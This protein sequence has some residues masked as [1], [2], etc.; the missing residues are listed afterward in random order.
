MK[1]DAHT[2]REYKERKYQKYRVEIPIKIIKELGWKKGQDLTPK[3]TKK[4]GL[5]I[6]KTK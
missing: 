4:K 5:L 1:L 3:I 2:S 6:K